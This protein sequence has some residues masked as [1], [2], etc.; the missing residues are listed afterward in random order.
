MDLMK[1]VNN[2]RLVVYGT[3]KRAGE[4]CEKYADELGIK[5]C[6]CSDDE[7]IPIN[8][9]TAVNHDDV[10]KENDYV[11]VCTDKYYTE[12][13]R[14]LRLSGY[15]SIIDFMRFDYFEKLYES[16]VHGKRIIIGVGRCLIH[17]I[18]DAM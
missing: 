9:M 4:F 18:C 6:T 10:S 2:R 7:F 15:M 12:I 8:G 16:T 1:L 14:Q 13:A 3:G 17:S 11:I 5:V